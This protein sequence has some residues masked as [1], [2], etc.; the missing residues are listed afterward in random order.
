ML[1]GLA[2]SASKAQVLDPLQV[3]IT[4]A[5]SS[6]ARGSPAL[7]TLEVRNVGLVPVTVSFAN[8]QKYEFTA[9]DASGAT[10]WTWSFGKTFD[11]ASSS[12]TLA[13][14][15]TV[16]YQ[17]T[18][19]YNANVGGPAADGSY[20]VRGTFL[21]NYTGRSGTKSAQKAIS[22]YTPDYLQVSFAADKSA[23]RRGEQALLS[24]TMTNTAPYAL[25]VSFANGQSYD[26][27]A[28]DAAGN[29]VWTWSFGKAFDGNPQTRTL[30][31]GETWTVQ[32]AWSFVDDAGAGVPDGDF[33]VSGVLLGNYLGRSGT[34]GGSQT[35]NLLTPDPL[36]VTFATDKSNYVRTQSPAQLSLV[37]TNISTYSVTIDFATG[38][39]YDFSARNS[40]GQVVWTWSNG[41]SFPPGPTQVVLA[42]GQSL[43]YTQTWSY[44]NNS[45]LPVA[46]GTYTV[47]GSFLGSWYAESSKGGQKQ[48]RV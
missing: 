46:D 15:E 35:L 13:A 31:P 12:R 17:E 39:T 34:K 30:A 42:P 7:L 8:G 25:E 23:Y 24:L 21:G 28:T 37:V 47:S 14:G 43:Q 40:S 20:T 27:N 5:Q 2:P 48:I 11:P 22:L 10:V 18:W 32:E 29:V 41:K 36:Q 26:F 33:A 3:S 19:T 16:R 1:V 6:Y 9:Q 44:V 45:G 38:K 4:T